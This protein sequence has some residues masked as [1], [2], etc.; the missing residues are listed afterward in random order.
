MTL[1]ISVTTPEGIVMASD[2]RQSQRNNKNMTRISTNSANKIFSINNRVI[3]ATA[4]LAFFADNSGIQRNVSEYIR[5]FTKLTDYE[6]LT[7]KEIAYQLHDF[8]NNKY[9]WEEQLEMS[10]QQ[11]KMEA[12]RSGSQII[13]MDKKSD[14]IEFKIRQP[15]GL[16]EDGKLNIE[17]I[18]ILISGYNTDGSSETYEIR[19]PGIIDI[20]R[21]SGEYGSTWIGQGDLVSRLIL[22]YDGRLL[23]LPSFGEIFQKNQE[24]TIQQLRG[25]EYNIQWGLLTL[26]DA[27]DL[28]VFLIKSTETLQ[29]YG[30][31]INMDIG[32]IQGVGGPIDVVVITKDNGIEWLKHKTLTVPEY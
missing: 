6:E 2:S 11:F 8:L 16:I 27:I 5:E 20:K 13:S 1:I 12:Q 3:V 4:G 18:N 24:Q 14:G 21:R 29:K 30:D 17:V 7:V 22:G 32:E 28:A 9:P 15:N 26:Q 10:A 31:G 19:S 25:L 23:N